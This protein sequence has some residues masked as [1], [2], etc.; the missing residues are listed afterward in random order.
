[1]TY[2]CDEKHLPC[3]VLLPINQHSRHAEVLGLQ[4][5]A[6]EPFKKR[7]WQRLIQSKIQNQALC[8]KMRGNFDAASKL[9][10]FSHSVKSGDSSN[11]EA[12][13]A[14]FYWGQLFGE[15]FR[16]QSD[17]PISMALNY[18]YSVLRSAVARGLVARG[19][20]TA[21]GV[22]H[23]NNLNAFNLADD[24]VEPFRPIVDYFVAKNID[25]EAV[26]ITPEL[27]AGLANLMHTQVSILGESLTVLR[28]IERIASS[29]VE[30]HRTGNPADMLLPQISL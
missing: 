13:A 19:L 14:R 6:S 18:G 22:H 28:G 12:T 8:L 3:S 7:C 4:I 1:M 17:Q 15:T 25:D 29:F 26:D 20:H 16:R 24:F 5:Q 2:I 10:N 11:V 27:R 23:K 30:A 21:L 9:T